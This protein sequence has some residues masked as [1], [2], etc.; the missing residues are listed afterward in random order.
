MT[1]LSWNA[2]TKRVAVMNKGRSGVVY[3]PGRSQPYTVWYRGLVDL[4]SAD[5]REALRYFQDCPRIHARK[6]A[7]S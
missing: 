5:E 6:K 1:A 3:H 4:F 7:A 2:K